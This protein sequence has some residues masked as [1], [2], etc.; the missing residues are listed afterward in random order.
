[1]CYGCSEEAVG[2]W[3][4][5]SEEPRHTDDGAFV[6]ESTMWNN[7]IFCG[8]DLVLFRNPCERLTIYVQ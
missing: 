2:E 4:A 6:L 5:F 7:K 3:T 1:M 8:G